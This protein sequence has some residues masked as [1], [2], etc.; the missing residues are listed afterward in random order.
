MKRS[1]PSTADGGGEMNRVTSAVVSKAMSD[2][3]SDRRSS[4]SV[5]P[6]ARS[7]GSR[8][9]QSAAVVVTMRVDAVSC[10]PMS[11]KN[12][13]PPHDVGAPDDVA[14]RERAPRG[15]TRIRPGGPPDDVLSVGGAHQ[16]S[17]PDDVAAPERV[18]A[19]YDVGAPHD[20]G[21]PH[22]VRAPDDGQVPRRLVREDR[23][24]RDDVGAPND[25]LRPAQ[26]LAIDR[27][28]RVEA[29]RQPPRARLR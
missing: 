4:L 23:R 16:R 3:A 11:L 21:A 17:A 20:I 19:P 13:R 14:R 1:N 18:A 2:A 27:R 22:D 7:T 9:R 15:R 8:L 29:R 5:A 12:D 25:V 24:P 10:A 6:A 26:S 28:E